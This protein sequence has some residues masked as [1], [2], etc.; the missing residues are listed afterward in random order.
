MELFVHPFQVIRDSETTIPVE[1]PGIHLPGAVPR[2]GVNLTAADPFN[3]HGFRGEFD[4]EGKIVILEMLGKLGP[5]L[6]HAELVLAL[7][8]EALFCHVEGAVAVGVDLVY[9]GAID[10]PFFH[11]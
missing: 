11:F 4:W 1:A 7:E 2:Q 3:P 10:R 9:R 8:E 6:P 5:G